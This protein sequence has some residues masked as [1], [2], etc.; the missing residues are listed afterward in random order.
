MTQFS[1]RHL[2]RFVSRRPNWCLGISLL[3]TVAAVFSIANRLSI[4]MDMSELLPEDSEVAR[5]RRDAVFDFGSFDFMLAVLEARGPGQADQ[6]RGAASELAEALRDPRFVQ[7]VTYRFEPVGITGSPRMDARG[8]ALLTEE[9]WQALQRSVTEERIGMQMRHLAGLLLGPLSQSQRRQRLRD[10]FNFARVIEE[11]V[12]VKSGPLKVNLNENYFM[13]EDGRMLLMLMW[14]VQPAT[15]V[16]F[17]RS[18]DQFLRETREGMFLRNP[19]WSDD[20]GD[21]ST[22]QFDILFFGPHYETIADTKVVQRDFLRTSV[23]SL[24]AVLALFFLAFRRPEALLFVAT[25]LVIG[26]VWTLGLASWYPGRLTQVTM[27]FSPILIGLGIDFSVHIYNRYLEEMKPGLPARAAL[28]TAVA[29]TGPSI[30]AGALTTMLAFVGMMFT[31]FVGFRELGLVAATGVACC[32]LAVILTLPPMLAYAGESRLGSFTRRPMPNFGLRRVY[33]TVSSYPRITVAAALVLCVYFGL[34]ARS[35]AFEDDFREL[36]QH[37][38]EYAALRDRITERFQVP[39]TQI[40]IILR[41]ETLEGALADNDR[42]FGNIGAA[43]TLYPLIAKDSLRYFYPSAETQRRQLAR[44]ADYDLEPIRTRIRRQAAE[45][46]LSAAIFDPF[47]ERLEAYQAAAREALAAFEEEGPPI[48]LTRIGRDERM[49]AL[50]RLSQRYITNE[51][52]EDWRV[53][54][55]LYP[56]PTADWATGI[57]E[58]FRAALSEGIESRIEITGTTIIQEELRRVIIRDLARAVLIILVL[59]YAYLLVY[60]ENPLRAALALLPVVISMLCVLGTIELLGM[61]LHYLNIIALPMLVGIGV[62]AGIHIIQRFREDGGRNLR[63]AVTRT[64][65]AVVITSLTTMFGFGSLA[66]AS[67]SGIRDLGLIAIMGV[68]YTMF[69]AL[70]VLPAVLRL[71]DPKVAYRGGGGDDLG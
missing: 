61:K 32:L 60:F 10:P 14:P 33:F 7:R 20:P 12:Q 38:E 51:G 64:G 16:G 11:R 8:I 35:V 49:L 52:G 63:N 40:I 26:V 15:D 57:P 44:M 39:T 17:A 24:L 55:R 46:R 13:S 29:G 22:R 70:M 19:H 21:P 34:H 66:F 1:L 69:A 25:P 36:R 23:I 9:D 48:D 68:V 18:F 43:E 71:L 27:A 45:N 4:E 58:P 30:F 53:V 41:N 42:L 3:A 62:D 28:Q 6:L 65:R 31:S 56:P 50:T 67:F 37:S 47:M 54:T 5:I 2:S 59:V